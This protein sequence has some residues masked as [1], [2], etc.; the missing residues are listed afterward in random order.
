[1]CR[2]YFIVRVKKHNKNIKKV[3]FL[4]LK[5]EKVG[6][7]ISREL[8]RGRYTVSARIGSIWLVF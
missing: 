4:C 5:R 6:I 1:V 8:W 2:L 7:N 3:A